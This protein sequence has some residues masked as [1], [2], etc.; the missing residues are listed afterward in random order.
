MTNRNFYAI[1]PV[2]YNDELMKRP[3]E[4]PKAY[5]SMTPNDN[6]VYIVGVETVFGRTDFR[7]TFSKPIELAEAEQ[8]GP[9]FNWKMDN[10][11]MY[12]DEK[13]EEYEFDDEFD[14]EDTVVVTMDDE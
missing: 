5:F 8:F 10:S 13:S 3:P 4:W 6:G 7:V 12:D 11:A 14:D 1:N 9:D 2:K